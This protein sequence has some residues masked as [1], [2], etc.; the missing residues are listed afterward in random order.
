MRIRFPHPMRAWDAFLGV[1]RYENVGLVATDPITLFFRM[2]KMVRVSKATL[3]IRSVDFFFGGFLG[4]E[5]PCWMRHTL[6]KNGN[7]GI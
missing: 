2:I 4:L 1:C 5:N 7:M 6:D 3:Y